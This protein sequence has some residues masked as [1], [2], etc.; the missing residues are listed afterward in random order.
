MPLGPI[1]LIDKPIPEL[2]VNEATFPHHA[3]RFKGVSV[4][5]DPNGFFVLTHRARSDI[6]DQPSDIP[7][8]VIES[9]ESTG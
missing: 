4:G 7:D 5:R 9:I 3:G 8:S 2:N 6:Y 1:T